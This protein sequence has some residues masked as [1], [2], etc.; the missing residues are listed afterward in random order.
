MPSRMVINTESIVGYNNMLVITDASMKVGVNNNVNRETHKASLKL[1]AGGPSKVNPPNSHPA[2]FIHKQAVQAQGLAP[3][4]APPQAL[5]GQ[6]STPTPPP[7][8]TTDTPAVAPPAQTASIDPH[9]VNKALIVVGALAL[10]G[11]V[12]WMRL[13]HDLARLV[14]LSTRK[15]TT[16]R[17]SS[18]A[19]SARKERACPAAFKM[20][21][22]IEP[23]RPV[24]APAACLPMFFR[25]LPIA[26][27]AAFNPFRVASTAALMVMP[28]ARTTACR[29]QPYFLKISSTLS[30]KGLCLSLTS[31]SVLTLASSA[32][33]SATRASAAFLSEGD[34]FSSSMTR[35]SSSIFCSISSFCCFSLSSVC[36]AS[37]F[38]LSLFMLLSKTLL[39]SSILLMS[40]FNL[41]TC[42]A[43]FCNCV[44]CCR[45]V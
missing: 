42:F 33:L 11:F 39:P 31:I 27:V 24:R 35:L 43:F 12:A 13:A 41:S 25:P 34:V 26:L 8:A 40:S 44:N 38:A 19:C 32:S 5:T 37:T 29:V 45:F 7:Q 18:Q 17:M 14:T 20:K 9:H 10:A 36:L 1:M 3:A 6:V 23:M 15:A 2:N 16:A 30:S 21:L 4:K 28:A 22:T